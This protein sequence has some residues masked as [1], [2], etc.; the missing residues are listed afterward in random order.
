MS[1]PPNVTVKQGSKRARIFP[2]RYAKSAATLHITEVSLDEL[3]LPD[4][5]TATRNRV[6][7]QG[8]HEWK[9]LDVT[10]AARVEHEALSKLVT[11]DEAKAP[12]CAFLLRLRCPATFW[13]EGRL[14][15]PAKHITQ[16]AAQTTVTLYREELRDV[17]EAQLFVVRTCDVASASGATGVAQHKGMRIADS[18]AC[19]IT[20]DAR[21]Q[22]SSKHLEINFIS[23]SS[24]ERFETISE[25]LYTLEAEGEHPILWLNE[26]HLEVAQVLS[27]EGTRGVGARLRDAF[28]D[29]I[30]HP[31]WIQL[32]LHAATSM[33]EEG[34]TP[35]EWQ[36]ALLDEFLPALFPDHDALAAVEELHRM[37]RDAARLPELFE[38]LDRH[39][40][41][42]QSY[43]A[44][45][46]KLATA[47]MR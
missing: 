45:M 32:F 15:S 21:H 5:F 3:E 18:T 14:L 24:H 4:H 39:L 23:F 27:M 47:A 31:V 2:H 19:A 26:D 44:H 35:F 16:S 17:V 40:Q 8:F 41:R 42:E 30:A 20:I 33:D 1:D 29:Q 10:F 46:V 43:V 6:D 36:Q 13:R 7:L 28:F 37:L 11:E 25:T 34:T 9:R 12:P 22:R 38:R